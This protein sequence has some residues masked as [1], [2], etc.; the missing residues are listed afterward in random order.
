MINTRKVGSYGL[1]PTYK[2]CITLTRTLHTGGAPTV[3][4]KC[5]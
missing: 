1:S 4:T 3:S 2:I 5:A